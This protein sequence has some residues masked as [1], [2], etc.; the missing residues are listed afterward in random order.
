MVCTIRKSGYYTYQ[1]KS[2]GRGTPGNRL[3]NSMAKEVLLDHL[4]TFCCAS[5]AHHLHAHAISSQ[6][7]CISLLYLLVFII[8]LLGL[9]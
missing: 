9:Q 3:V 4:S 6:G 7:S 8:S 5:S 2:R 1:K